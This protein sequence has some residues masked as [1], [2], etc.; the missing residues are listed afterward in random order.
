[1]MV[2]IVVSAIALVALVLGLMVRRQ[3][4]TAAGLLTES[5][6]TNMAQ[7]YRPM[8]RLLDNED[9]EVLNAAGDN[10]LLRR[11]RSQRRTIFRG[12]L[13]C[14]RRDHALLCA[15]VRSIMI[16]SDSDRKDLAKGLLK[17]EW[18]FKFFLVGVNARLVM[19]AAGVGTVDVN[20][21]LGSFE[22]VR[23]CLESLTPRATTTSATAY[24]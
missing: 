15:R 4:L 9:F 24:A 7:R 6:V 2:L 20:G 18:T 10:K 19:H 17:I 1:L 11:I 14:L 12:Y 22:Q 8:A 21:L 5:G 3:P 13:R 23:E 16:N